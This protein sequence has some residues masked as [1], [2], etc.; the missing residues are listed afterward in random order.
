MLLL[1][2]LA[3]ATPSGDTG[4]V[5]P[6]MATFVIALGAEPGAVYVARAEGVAEPGETLLLEVVDRDH[7]ARL[8]SSLCATDDPIQGCATLDWSVGA[9]RLSAGSELF[10]HP[11]LRLSAETPPTQGHVALGG[12]PEVFAGPMPALADGTW[13]LELPLVYLLGNAA[14]DRRTPAD[15]AITLRA[16]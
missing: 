9:P 13:T 6:P 10:L 1:L 2:L 15:L 16:R 11:D 8:Q 7:P 4:E 14:D 12:I 3:C 5:P